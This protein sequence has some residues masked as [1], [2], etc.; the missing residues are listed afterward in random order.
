M[1]DPAASVSAPPRFLHEVPVA[2]VARKKRWSRD[3]WI[4]YAFDAMEREGLGAVRIEELARRS[5]RTPGSFYAHFKSRDELLEAMLEEWVEFK[6]AA[7]MKLD[8]ALFR[9]GKF[10]LEGIFERVRTGTHRTARPDLDL[11]IREW[12]RVDDRA[13]AAVMRSDML[14]MNNGTSMVLAEFPNAPHPQVFTLMF[15]WLLRGRWVTFTD[16]KEK[17][18]NESWDL[19]AEA[20]VRMYKA[21]ADKFHVPGAPRWVAK[22]KPIPEA[23]D[24]PMLP[25]KRTKP[26]RKRGRR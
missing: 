16:P 3:D 5:A 19:A 23:S 2:E 22:F 6:L 21:M 18:L 15:L 1:L 9:A 14:R 11:A 4:V 7:T 20:F 24:V 10:T 17:A 25:R 12:A 8:S 26:P 13:R